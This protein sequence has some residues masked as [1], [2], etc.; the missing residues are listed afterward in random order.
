MSNQN[1]ST[2]GES[3]DNFNILYTIIGIVAVTAIGCVTYSH[4]TDSNNS[5]EIVSR[6]IERGLDPMVASCAANVATNNR[7]V[8]STCEKVNIIKGK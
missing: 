5:K 4:V 6:A 2:K 1:K 3:M 7:D 8:R